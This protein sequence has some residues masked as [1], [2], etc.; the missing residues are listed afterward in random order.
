MFKFKTGPPATRLHGVVMRLGWWKTRGG[1]LAWVG[2][3][4]PVEINTGQWFVGIIERREGSGEM[5]PFSWDMDGE[6]SKKSYGSK[7]HRD[8]LIELLP[9]CDG[10]GFLY[11]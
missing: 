11:A 3:L 1:D 7:E 5:E 6:S 9:E 4:S 10:F 8:D 2:A